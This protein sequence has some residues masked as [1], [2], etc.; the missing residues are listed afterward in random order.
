MTVKI[1][2]K[3]ITNLAGIPP[4][5]QSDNSLSFEGYYATRLLLDELRELFR[6]APNGSAINTFLG[7]TQFAYDKTEDSVLTQYCTF[8]SGY[9]IDGWYVLQ[10]FSYNPE[11]YDA[12]FPFNVSLF[13]L[14]TTANVQLGLTVYDLEEEDSDWE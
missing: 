4:A 9:L 14:G 6:K 10:R 8:N 11:Q 12:Y 13:F 3:T 7:G 5:S 2:S 1:G